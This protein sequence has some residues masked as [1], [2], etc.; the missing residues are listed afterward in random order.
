MCENSLSLL[1]CLVGGMNNSWV[2]CS[3][4]DRKTLVKLVGCICSASVSLHGMGM[5]V[6]CLDINSLLYCFTYFCLFIFKRLVILRFCAFLLWLVSDSDAQIEV[7]QIPLFLYMKNITC[8]ILCSRRITVQSVGAEFVI[9][10]SRCVTVFLT[11]CLSSAR[12][13]L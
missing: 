7:R 1:C 8:C 5:L 13:H 3:L 11:L 2:P 4:V 12:W 10:W 9:F 6:C